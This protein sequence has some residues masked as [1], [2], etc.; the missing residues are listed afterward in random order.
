VLG[1]ALCADGSRILGLGDLGINGLG[2]PVGKLDLYVAAAGFHPSK[3]RPDMMLNVFVLACQHLVRCP[4]TQL[5]I[6]SAGLPDQG[7]SHA[8]MVM[9]GCALTVSFGAGCCAGAALCGGC[10]H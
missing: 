10:G 4:W 5:N 1:R 8:G 7:A 6:Q 9:G 3:V 2:I